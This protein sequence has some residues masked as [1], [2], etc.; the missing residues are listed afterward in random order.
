[1]SRIESG[2][3]TIKKEEFSFSKALEQVNTIISGQCRDRGLH[4]DCQI[5]GHVDITTSE[6]P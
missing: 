3:M 4:Y 2:R 6:T 1:M 5:M